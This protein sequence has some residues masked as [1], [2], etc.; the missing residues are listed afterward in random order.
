LHC[1]R[2]ENA[3]KLSVAKNKFFCGHRNQGVSGEISRALHRVATSCRPSMCVRFL[4]RK[5]HP[6]RQS[7]A[8]RSAATCAIERMSRIHDSQDNRGSAIELCPV[9]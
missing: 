2:V 1:T 7:V 5:S 9:L 3:L 6:N 8:S 4:S